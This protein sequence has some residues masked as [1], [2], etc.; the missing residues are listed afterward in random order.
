M[1]VLLFYFYFYFFYCGW[2]SLC[3][4]IH[5]LIFKSCSVTKK[6]CFSLIVKED[7]QVGSTYL[8]VWKTILWLSSLHCRGTTKNNSKSIWRSTW[9]DQCRHKWANQTSYISTNHVSRSRGAES[10]SRQAYVSG[11]VSITQRRMR[12]ICLTDHHTSQ[13]CAASTS[14]CSGQEGEEPLEQSRTWIKEM[15]IIEVKWLFLFHLAG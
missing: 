12:W 6:L 14:W 10:V 1:V 13:E 11:C 7:F 5:N 3:L 4:T 9:R 15:F 2:M 8:P